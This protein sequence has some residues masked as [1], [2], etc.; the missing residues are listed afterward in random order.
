MKHLSD[1]VSRG[2]NNYDEKTSHFRT[3]SLKVAKEFLVPH[4]SFTFTKRKDENKSLEKWS[5]KNSKKFTHLTMDGE[6]LDAH[7]PKKWLNI[8]GNYSKT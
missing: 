2:S 6:F 8:K 7:F 5:F 4:F 1:A 3:L